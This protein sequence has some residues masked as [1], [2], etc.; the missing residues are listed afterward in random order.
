MK[1]ELTDFETILVTHAVQTFRTALEEKLQDTEPG[2]DIE[3]VY[4]F[5]WTKQ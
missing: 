5:N 4:G 1:T 2:K 3:F